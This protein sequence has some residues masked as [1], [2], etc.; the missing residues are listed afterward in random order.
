MLELKRKIRQMLA[1][2]FGADYNAYRRHTWAL[3]PLLF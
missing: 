1:Q 3:V 2:A